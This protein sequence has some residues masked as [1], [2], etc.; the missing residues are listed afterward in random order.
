MSLTTTNY[1]IMRKILIIDD[2]LDVSLEKQIRQLLIQDEII[3]EPTAEYAISIFKDRAN[4]FDLVLLDIHFPNQPLDG[5]RIFAEL[6]MIRSNI[7]IV[8]LTDDADRGMYFHSLGASDYIKK[9]DFISI[10]EK[11]KKLLEGVIEDPM[12]NAYT[13]KVEFDDVRFKIFLDI[14]DH[15]GSILKERICKRATLYFLLKSYAKKFVSNREKNRPRSEDF[16]RLSDILTDPNLPEKILN[17]PNLPEKSRDSDWRVYFDNPK[18]LS[19]IVNRINE[20]VKKLSNYRICGI[21]ESK[22]YATEAYR[23][24]I[25]AI[26]IE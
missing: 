25:G 24:L 8:I 10:G 17:D 23:F 12:N 21:L 4:E 20:D 5:G 18:Y 22:G 19:K 2:D 14:F 1:M 15:H 11:T 7:P 26:V 3:T 13:L 6:K 9:S 16:V